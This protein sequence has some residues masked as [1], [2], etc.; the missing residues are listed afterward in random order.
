MEVSPGILTLMQPLFMSSNS[1]SRW[2]CAIA[3]VIIAVAALTG[4]DIK[5]VSPYLV[6]FTI[7][8]IGFPPFVL[9]EN[10]QPDRRWLLLPQEEA[11]KKADLD[12]FA[13]S[14]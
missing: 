14:G 13:S 3:Q 9:A 4:L 8:A 2:P 5:M 7:G 11:N 10:L 6:C 1:Q 12:L